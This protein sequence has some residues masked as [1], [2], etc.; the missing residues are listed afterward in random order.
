[1]K[2]T[3]NGR[4]QNLSNEEYQAATDYISRSAILDFDKSP[5]TYWANYI[6]PERKKKETSAINIGSAFHTYI[7]QPELFDKQF[8]VEPKKVLLK[9][10]G[11]EEFDAY[12]AQL[13]ALEKAGKSI[14][15]HKEYKTILAMADKFKNNKDVELALD[16]GEIENSFFWFDEDNKLGLKARPD[17]YFN[18]G[19]V[20]DIKTSNDASPRHYQ[21]DMIKYGYHIQAAMIKDG[22]KRIENVDISHFINIVIETKYPHNIGIY[23]I[24]ETAIDFGHA[25]YRKILQ[26][27]KVAIETNKFQDYGTHTIGLPKWAI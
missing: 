21:N 24:D 11:R 17:V 27:L 3:Y 26:D 1:M 15:S 13:S 8:A 14:L 6:N 2:K 19:V 20:L 12:K 18:N 22:V 9:D 4:F 23:F 10:V 16:G 25:K 7:L 5:Y